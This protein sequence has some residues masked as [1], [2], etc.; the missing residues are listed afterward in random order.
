MSA[1]NWTICPECKAKEDQRQADAHKKAAESYGKVS[2]DK[3]D[4]LRKAALP[5]VVEDTLREDYELGV[6]KDGQ[7]YVSYRCSCEKCDFEHV[8]KHTEKLKIA[9]TPAGSKGP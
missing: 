4:S 6:G 1:D 7:F 9:S 3:F 2:V 8:F 5:L